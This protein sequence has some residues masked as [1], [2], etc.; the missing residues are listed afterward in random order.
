[1]MVKETLRPAIPLC[2]FSKAKEGIFSLLNSFCCLAYRLQ[3][4]MPVYLNIRDLQSAQ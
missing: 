2:F 1:M 4:T 3:T